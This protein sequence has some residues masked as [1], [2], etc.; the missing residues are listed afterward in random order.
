MIIIWIV[1]FSKFEYIVYWCNVNL[2]LN[3]KKNKL[4]LIDFVGYLNGVWMF[5]CD[6]LLVWKVLRK[7]KGNNC[8]F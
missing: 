3:S 7:I 6:Y 2:G 4:C 8:V 5:V 1:K